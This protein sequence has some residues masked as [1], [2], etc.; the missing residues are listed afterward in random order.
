MKVAEFI[1]RCDILGGLSCGF[2]N[3]LSSIDIVKEADVELF[4]AIYDAKEAW[5]KY[6]EAEDRYY[7]LIETGEY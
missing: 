1:N 4:E 6:K 5:D 2:N 7:T 3:G